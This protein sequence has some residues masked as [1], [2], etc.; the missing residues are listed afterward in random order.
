MNILQIIA[1]L[2][3]VETGTTCQCDND[4]HCYCMGDNNLAAGQLQIHKA[5]LQDANEHLGTSYVWPD[6]CYDRAKSVEIVRGYMSRYLTPE[7]LGRA[8]L[9]RDIARS[10]VG[11]LNGYKKDCTLSYWNTFKSHLPK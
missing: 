2:V 10:H 3:M 6:D 1:I 11:G 4:T 8:V 9:V 7:R 5:Y